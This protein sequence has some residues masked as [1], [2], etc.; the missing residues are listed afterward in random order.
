MCDRFPSPDD[1]HLQT[2]YQNWNRQWSLRR[3]SGHWLGRS[4]RSFSISRR[5]HTD[6][7]CNTNEPV[8]KT[9]DDSVENGVCNDLLTVSLRIGM[10]KNLADGERIPSAMYSC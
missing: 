10:R 2:K 1:E 4:R 3:A 5:D 8:S 9:I 7:P 6:T